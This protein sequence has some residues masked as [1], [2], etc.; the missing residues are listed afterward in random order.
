MSQWSKNYAIK[1]LQNIKQGFKRAISWNKYR[2][3]ITTQPENNKFD[4]IIDPIFRKIYRLF[5]LSF[6]IGGI[7]PKRHSFDKYQMV[8]VGIKGFYCIN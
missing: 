5:V 7:D 3:E 6:K 8:L 2:S 1:F 4:Y